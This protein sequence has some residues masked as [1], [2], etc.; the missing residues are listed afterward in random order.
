MTHRKLELIADAK[1]DDKP[2]IGIRVSGRTETPMVLLFDAATKRLARI[3]WRGDSNRFTDWRQ[4]DGLWYPAKCAGF[5][6]DGR[7]WYH[8]ELLEVER[9]AEVP[10]HLK[11]NFFAHEP[12]RRAMVATVN[13]L[14]TTAAVEAM[15]AGGNAVDGAIA[16]AVMLGV[17]D[18]HNSGIGGGFFMLI[19]KPDGSFIALDGREIAPAA[20]TRD[21][22]LREGKGDGALS[23]EGPLA[24]GVPGWLAALDTAARDFGKQPQPCL[25]LELDDGWCE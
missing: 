7:E 19:R 10:A 1:L 23:Q 20:A 11:P 22:F 3:D 6:P 21:I 9:L 13:P 15:R 12:P 14:A 5:K 24:V 2:A 18:S 25:T 17:V 8:T 16:A 4:L